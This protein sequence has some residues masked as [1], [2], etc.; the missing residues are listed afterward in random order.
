M[1][2]RGRFVTLALCCALAL[3]ACGSS[4]PNKA[5]GPNPTVSDPGPNSTLSDPG[6]NPTDNGPVT[7][8]GTLTIKGKCLEL[9][10]AGGPL[11]LRFNGYSAKGT[12]LID[13][14]KTAVAKSGDHI[15]VAGKASTQK[16]ACGTRFDVDNLVTVLPR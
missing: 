14:T 4:H 10:H 2:T 13:D 8:E 5:L 9:Q 15:A 1:A 16:S 11:D 3:G 7:I 12:T 6:P